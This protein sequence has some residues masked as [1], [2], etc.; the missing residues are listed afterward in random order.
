VGRSP[1]EIAADRRS[2]AAE[3]ARRAAE[4]V[5]ALP[6]SDLRPALE[7]LL[8]GHPEMAPLWRLAGD[9]LG[10]D[11]RRAARRFLARVDR[12][13]LGVA[14]SSPP[15]LVGPVVTLS[16]SGSL[17]AAVA[18]AGV[19]AACARSEPGGEGEDTARR[20]RKRG[21]EADVVSDEESLARARDGWTAVVGADAIGPSGV[22][23]K[24]GTAALARAATEGG[25]SCLVVAGS[26]KFLD[27]DLPTRHPFERVPLD[28]F[29]AFLSEAGPLS[30][31]DAS[32]LSRRFALEP[33]LED[34]LASLA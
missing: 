12:E 26:T 23:N 31:A 29:G 33:A 34:L 14:A 5:A 2:G 22:V 11:P 17:V 30:P 20:L 24:V 10:S 4:A 32:W 21:I 25:A 9:V 27:H 15:M 8:R 28:A 19:R 3:L 16:S 6:S 7:T 18:A 13:A 1:E